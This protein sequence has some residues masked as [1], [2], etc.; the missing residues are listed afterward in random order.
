MDLRVWLRM[1]EKMLETNS[2]G[3]VIDR[4]ALALCEAEVGQAVHL[5]DRAL[6]FYRRQ[7]RAAIQKMREPTAAMVKIGRATPVSHSWGRDGEFIADPDQI[8]QAM[9]DEALK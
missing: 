6:G 3:M 9:V 2:G 5:S 7:A 4:V 1:L 8:W